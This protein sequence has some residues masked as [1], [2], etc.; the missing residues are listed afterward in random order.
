[1]QEL[2]G[3]M[4]LLLGFAAL[5]S[6]TFAIGAGIARYFFPPP[7]PRSKTRHVDEPE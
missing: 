4:A 5:C 7:A 3:Y 1:M 2:L 6:G